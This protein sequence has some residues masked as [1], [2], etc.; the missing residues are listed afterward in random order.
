MD[1][2]IEHPHLSHIT[3]ILQTH[4]SYCFFDKLIRVVRVSLQSI[5]LLEL[6][7]KVC[8]DL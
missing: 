6:S 2:S 5:E 7:H 8:I 4:Y 1:F 3:N